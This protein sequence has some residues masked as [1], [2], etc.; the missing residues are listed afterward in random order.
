MLIQVAKKDPPSLFTPS[1][2]RIWDVDT[3]RAT[4]LVNPALTGPDTN[5][6]RHPSLKMAIRISIMP[7]RKVRST[8]LCQ[9]PWA[10]WKVMSEATA[11]LPIVLS[12]QVPKRT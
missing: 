7:V 6:T 11:V 3:I 1:I 10:N 2:E 5:S 4:A 12:L 9:D 8:D